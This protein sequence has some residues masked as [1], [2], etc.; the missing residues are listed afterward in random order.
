MFS[1]E[2]TM[3]EL[4]RELGIDPVELRLK[5][6]SEEGDPMPNGRPWPR[7]GL[8]QCLEQLRDHPA[9]KNRGRARTRASA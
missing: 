3:D 8:R 1:V 4:A 7:I 6:A 9:W 5:N 2:S